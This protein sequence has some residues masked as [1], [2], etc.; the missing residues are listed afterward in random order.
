MNP[1]PPAPTRLVPSLTQACAILRLLAQQ[2]EP[3]GLSVIARRLEISPSSCFN[4]LKTLV[5]ED[6][7]SFDGVTKRYSI[8]L[9]VVQLARQ[10]LSRDAVV[11]ASRPILQ[12][13]ADEMDA[14][15]ALWRATGRERLTLVTLSEGESAARIHMA[16]GQRQPIGG[17]AAGRA[18]L[19][20]RRAG[21]AELRAAFAMVRWQ[22]EP[23]FGVYR[24]D[25]TSVPRRG[26]AMDVDQMFRGITTVAAPICEPGG[27]ATYCLSISLFSRRHDGR[28]L[29]SMGET[30]ARQAAEIALR[31]FGA[32]H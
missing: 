5:D 9:G 21:E 32:G 10:S 4:I 24:D 16:V 22:G 19:G 26:F 15:A 23:D 28:A 1:V 3:L 25:V 20:V 14:A 6:L 11:L 27:G 8:G 12:R 29:K 18:I 2:T 7:A 17:G 30:L 31:V 13:L